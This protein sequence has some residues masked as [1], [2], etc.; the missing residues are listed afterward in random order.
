MKK[1]TVT[2][3][4]IR[5][6]VNGTHHDP[7]NAL[8]AH[9]ITLDGKPAVAI[10]AFL[11]HAA[12]AAVVSKDSDLTREMVKVDSQGFFEAVFE[13][14][15]EIFVYRLRLRDEEGRTW[16]IW[17]PYSFWP[18][19][20]DFDIYLFSEGKLLESYNHLG[21]HPWK[22]GEISGTLFAVWAPNASRVSV[23]G[24]FNSWDGK[25]HPMRSRG[26]SGLWE[27]FIPDLGEG[28][29]YKYEILSRHDN[30]LLLKAD[31]HAFY[32]EM[33]P[34]TASIVYDLDRYAWGD[35]DWQSSHSK[36]SILR[37]PISIYEVHPGSWRRKGGNPGSWLCYREL[38]HELVAYVKDMGF[39]H[40]ELMPISE[41]PLDQSWG[42][43]TTGYFSVTSRYGTPGDFQY[44]V[45]CCHQNGIGVIIDWVPAHFP[46]DEHGLR[47]FDGTHL[48]EHSDPRKG[49]HQDWGTAIFNFGRTEVRNFLISNA[50][51]WLEKYHVDGLRVDAVASMIYLDYSRQPGEWIPNKYGG[52][53]NLEAIAFL[54]DLNILV[55][56]RHPNT[57][58]IAE[59]STAWPGVTRPA[60]LGGL[61]F[62]L[63]WNMGWMHDM[64]SYFSK[65]PIHRKYHHNNLTFALLYAFTENFALVFSHDEVVHMKG[66]MIAK[67]PGDEWQKFANLRALYSYMYA[68]PGKKLLFMGDEFGQW[69]EWDS[70]SSL[71]WDLLRYD[72]HRKLQ[73]CIRDLN[74]LY[75]QLPQ[76]H[77][78]DF[79]HSGFEWIDFAD[80]E[81]SVISF[82]RNSADF[83]NPVIVVGNF[84]PMP[85]EGYRIGIPR[86]GLYKVLFNS[87]AEAY[88]GGNMGN[89]HA[90]QAEA[91][92]CQGRPYSLNLTLPPLAV[93]YLQ[94]ET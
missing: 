68:F 92:G 57:L 69:S 60:H 47:C 49:H 14:T 81:S 8:G 37:Q 94:S 75:R 77:A 23:V 78:V 64:L 33:R 35:A 93:L 1:S 34:Q 59:E 86:E 53:E 36:D 40:V 26:L 43:Q 10:R 30:A 70:E 12:S 50:L 80:S 74:Q 71:D 79:H 46:T 58:M 76:F 73:A 65:D 85:R 28:E 31:P 20:T 11:P 66:S 87:D 27:L 62:T 21:A 16:E 19:L 45:D 89:G 67:M 24:D 44:F 48:Y 18:V 72:P 52:N 38:A 15:G 90:V 4:E 5:Q 13:E 56:G 3:I 32:S 51:F 54:R 9:K 29:K 25:R 22:C 7:F 83:K 63:K 39:T 6:I 2:E 82:L 88:G 91:I 41:H 55:H 84:T 42:Y 17:D 61:G